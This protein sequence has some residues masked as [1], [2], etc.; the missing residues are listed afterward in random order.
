MKT[1]H[2]VIVL[3][4]VLGLF[5]WVVDAVLDYFFFYEG[6]FLEI[7]I[8]DVPFHEIYIRSFVLFLFIIFGI[9][10]SRLLAEY[11]PTG[12]VLRQQSPLYLLLI[13]TGSIFVV[14]LLA[15]FLISFMPHQSFLHEALLDSLILVVFVFPILYFFVF[16]PLTSYIF[17][18]KR[19]EEALQKRTYDLGERVKELKGLYGTSQLIADPD[20]TLE[21]VFQGAVDLIP[22]SWQYPEI[23]CARITFEGKEFKTANWKAPKWMQTADII[24]IKKKAGV[25]EVGYLEQKPEIDEGPFFKEERNLIN[26]LARILGDFI[27]RKMAEEERDRLNRELMDKNKELEQII[28]VSSHDLRSPLVNIQGFSK[29]LDNAF[30]EV[31][32]ALDSKDVSPDIKEELAPY[33][34]DDIP[35]ALQ[36]I[37]TSTIKMDSLISGLLQLSRL[38]RAMLRFKRLNMNHLVS[39]V[40]SVFEYQ[41]KEQDVKVEVDDL[42]MCLGD[43]SQ[44]NQVFS[45]LLDNALKNLSPDRAGV[46]KITGRKED[47][48]IVYCMD[49]N[50]VG[51]AQEHQEKIFE[52]FH[53]LNPK[54]SSG[55]GLGL[56]FARKI[57]D[58]HRG[59]IWVESE[60][61]EGSRFFISLPRSK[62]KKRERSVK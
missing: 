3:S 11:E 18:R 46:I 21:G 56:T 10:M 58:M 26:G 27:E 31:Q 36:Y 42:P 62:N 16:R 17:E 53:R 5:F 54:T 24:T 12:K 38:G 29:E 59:R 33:L 2:K 7:L 13:V 52:I 49:D 6:T 44:I 19:A 20:S 30:K 25:I 40:I 32:R 43:G 61:D 51:I 47:K 57:L 60:K 8:S 22:P 15:M 55:E 37:Q 45:N 1:E 14:E 50:G 34:E 4:A 28:Y 39:E 9:I 41:I 23:T 35:E 48:E